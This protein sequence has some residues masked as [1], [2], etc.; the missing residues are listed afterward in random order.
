MV[1]NN[2]KII[3]IHT[4]THKLYATNEIYYQHQ[5]LDILNGICVYAL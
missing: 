5:T 4:H 1:S 2:N 3:H